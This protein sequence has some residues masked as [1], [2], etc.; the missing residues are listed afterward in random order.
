ME[1]QYR[2]RK[3]KGRV[4]PS[5]EEGSRLGPDNVAFEMDSIRSDNELFKQLQNGVQHKINSIRALA[6]VKEGLSRWRN[7]ANRRRK[8]AT[9]VSLTGEESMETSKTGGIGLDDIHKEYT[10]R[11]QFT[12]G[13][14]VDGKAIKDLEMSVA[15][16]RSLIQYF[17]KLGQS[18]KDD[19]SVNLDFVESLLN[20][21]ADINC[22]DKFGQTILHEVARAW[23]TDVARFLIEK[24]AKVD[25]KDSFGRT[26]LHF[27]AAVDYPEMVNLLI[28]FKA[29]KEAVTDGE[30]QTPVHYA[31]KNDACKSLKA[32]AKH[33]C[34]VMTVRDYKGRTPIHVAAELDRSES[35]RFLLTLGAPAGVNDQQGQKAIAWMITKMAPVANDALNQFRTTDRASRKQNVYLNL[36]VQNETQYPR[37]QSPLLVA[38]NHRQYQLLM[39][40]CF[41][42]LIDMMWSKFGAKGAWINLIINFI[43]IVLWTIIGVAIEYDERYLYKFPDH[44]WRIVLLI[45]AVA[46]TVWQIVEELRE[47]RRSVVS[48]RK[49]VDWRKGEIERDRKYCHPRWPDEEK[50]LERELNALKEVE[51]SY[52]SDM[53]NIFD[54]TCYFLLTICIVTHLFDIG[55]HSEHLARWH[56]RIMCVTIILLWLRLM[57]NARA[58]TLLGPFIVMLGH[59]LKDCVRFLFLYLEFYIPYACAFWM[60]FGGDR[61]AESDINDLSKGETITVD[62]YEY[63]GQVLFSLFRLTLVD[64]YDFS[65]MYL[66]DSVMATI[67]VW[68]WLALSA[69]LCL[70]LFIALLSD[71]FQRIYDNAIANSVMQRAI[72]ILSIWE[73]MSKRQKYKFQDFID[74]KCS[75][76]EDY[77]DDDLTETGE[78]DI[79]K[80]TVQIK[81]M[82]DDMQEQWKFHFGETEEQLLGEDPKPTLL[83]SDKNKRSSSMVTSRK[84]DIEIGKIHE[85]IAELSLQ[86]E[87]IATT[88][89]H[90]L[91]SVKNMLKELTGRRPMVPTNE[92]SRQEYD[93]RALSGMPTTQESITQGSFVEPVTSDGTA[94][95]MGVFPQ[96]SAFSSQPTENEVEVTT[97][98]FT[99]NDFPDLPRHNSTA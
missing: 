75:P 66:V 84:F 21:G 50:F 65:N 74:K 18:N 9:R 23:H 40:P 97:A 68:S 64:D 63:P 20:A 31:A 32:L 71:T 61:R 16:N 72:T 46:L 10:L 87:K 85:M 57:K 58:F 24:G 69:V 49:W 53:W 33:G 79:Q 6:Q 73:K 70:N 67:L 7:Y 54:W 29:N 47:Y 25:K 22:M 27:A 56:V 42:R 90:D 82:L 34:N 38:V 28:E 36:L 93:E 44:W 4:V 99:T 60:I 35:S 13:G 80:V 59:M 30:L 43:Y 26:P 88:F 77:Y 92:R 37:C 55:M 19:E 2:K 17:A 86:Q 81:D 76:I 91:K 94:L 48:H 41:R 62:G 83:P 8:V 12:V 45:S 78:A 1:E 89:K 5:S 96:G 98:R 11:G 3:K 52:F 15:A 51:Q 95:D 14:D 39:H